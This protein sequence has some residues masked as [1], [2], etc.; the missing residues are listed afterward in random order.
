MNFVKLGGCNV[1]YWPTSGQVGVQ[2]CYGDRGFLVKHKSPTPK[3]RYIRI[4]I[5]GKKYRAHHLAF[6][7]M[8]GDPLWEPPAGY[9]IDHVDGNKL[10][11]AWTNLELVTRQENIRRYHA[12]K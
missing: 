6:K 12:S 9:E 8:L 11:N 2:G 3:E 10:N 5:G 4:F 1:F 7:C